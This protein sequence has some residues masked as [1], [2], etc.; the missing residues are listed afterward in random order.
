MTRNLTR[1]E[2]ALAEHIKGV[3]L[4]GMREMI[5]SAVESEQPEP[6]DFKPETVERI[7]EVVRAIGGLIVDVL[8]TPSPRRA[9]AGRRAGSGS[10][11][12]KSARRQP[13]PAPQRAS[14]GR[15]RG[16]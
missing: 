8:D 4:P 2:L 13:G 16:T 14:P 3:V 6:R 15:S 9:T 11:A 10:K 7:E 1:S 5:Q 12:G